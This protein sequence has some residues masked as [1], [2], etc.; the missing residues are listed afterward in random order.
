MMAMGGV[1]E[2]GNG[3][4]VLVLCDTGLDAFVR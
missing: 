1:R 4:G 2:G 3:E